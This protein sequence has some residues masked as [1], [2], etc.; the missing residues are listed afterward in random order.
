M[1]TLK[2]MKYR[3]LGP[4]NTSISVIG[5]GAAAISGEGGGY[6][7]G[8]ISES[9][10]LDLVHEAFDCG[11]NIF[12]TAPIY[13]FGLSEERLGKALKD[14]GEKAL[15]VSK[16][17]V[18]WHRGAQNKRVNMSN[19][20]KVTERMLHESLKRL[21]RD[22]IDVYMVH[23][24]DKNVDIRRPLEVLAKAKAQD[25]IRFIGLCNTNEE[26]LNKAFEIDDI[27]V[28][29]GEFN[30]L[31][32]ENKNL[33]PL[34]K[35]RGLGFMS[36]GTLEKGIL[37]GRVRKKRKY[38]S[39]DARSWA[40]WWKKAPTSEL[41]DKVE[42]LERKYPEFNG[43]SLALGHNLNYE[44]VSTC[45]CGARSKE[46]LHSLIKSLTKLPPVELVEKWQNESL[47]HN[48]DL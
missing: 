41:V 24:P 32:P 38:D 35:N 34:L 23:W 15:V 37:T 16:S 19:D 45:L 26:D 10:A 5:F 1:L 13:G 44:Q 21:D 43:L 11:I 25:K 22:Y 6:G 14:Y 2:A 29:Q 42:N 27:E 46:Q 39:S 47:S 3:S 20:P 8:E 31:K 9:D 18:D 4:S 12:D 17:G 36:W 30:F 28:V 7:F 48:P 33:F 40:P